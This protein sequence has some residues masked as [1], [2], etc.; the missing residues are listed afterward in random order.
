MANKAWQTIKALKLLHL[1]STVF[2][3]IAGKSAMEAAEGLISKSLV[4]IL[5]AMSVNDF[6]RQCVFIIFFFL[7]KFPPLYF[8]DTT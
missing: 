6:L 4:Y 1:I 7:V 8:S 2:F 3:L 5:K